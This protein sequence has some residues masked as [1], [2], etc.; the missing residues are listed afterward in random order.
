MGQVDVD[1]PGRAPSATAGA[2]R[3]ARRHRPR[4]A[5]GSSA[6]RCGSSGRAWRSGCSWA[7]CGPSA[8]S[9]SPPWSRPPSTRASRRATRPS[10]PGS[11]S[12]S[13]SWA[14]SAPCSP[15]CAATRPSGRPAG[16][17]PTCATGCSPTCSA[18]TSRS[19]TRHQTGQLMSR[20]N[21][22][23]QQIQNFVVLI[24]LTISNAVTVAGRHRHP[25]QR[26]ERRSWRVLAL[27]G[28]PFVNVL[29]KRFSTRLHPTMV[30]VQQESAELAGVVEE[31]VSGVRVVKGFGAE[32]VQAAP[33]APRGRRPLRRLDG[34]RPHPGPLLAGARAAPQPRADRGAGLR[35]PPGDRR[36]A[37]PRRA[38]GVQRL[39]R[40][41]DLAP[42][43][44]RA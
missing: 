21:T 7:W 13:A 32:H 24:P 10:P 9:P 2:I 42:A 1:A 26:I 38:G 27:G 35:R 40:P 5:G 20:A 44:A 39:R 18:C 30:G 3:R 17:R 25:V 22:D 34:G 33:P 12:S 28:L 29:A 4:T 36:P 43:D 6:P 41:A 11:R 15:G 14:S 19:T 8:R 37:Q 23:L 16:P 31:T